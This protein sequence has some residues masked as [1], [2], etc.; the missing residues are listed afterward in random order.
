M[1]NFPDLTRREFAERLDFYT[2]P[3][4]QFAYYV[5]P[6]K[7]HSKYQGEMKAQGPLQKTTSLA[8]TYVYFG[9]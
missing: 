9:G 6:Q 3:A 5:S 7:P 2:S 1:G 8:I 4:I